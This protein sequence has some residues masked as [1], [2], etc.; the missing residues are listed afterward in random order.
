MGLAGG[1][2]AGG[3]R[4]LDPRLGK[5]W[6]GLMIQSVVRHEVADSPQVPVVLGACGKGKPVPGS[7][8]HPL[9]YKNCRTPGGQKYR[10]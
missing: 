9:E 10:Q 4:E 1:E 8:G 3:S 5:Q 6:D 7:F 2:L